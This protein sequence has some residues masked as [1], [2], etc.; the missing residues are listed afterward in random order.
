MNKGNGAPPRTIV[1]ELREREGVNERSTHQNGNYEVKLNKPVMLENGD[2]L[3][4]KSA[5]VDSVQTSAGNL[6]LQE[7]VPVEI[8]SGL[9]THNY[10]TTDK[11][12]NRGIGAQPPA[13]QPDGQ[14]YVLC[15][16]SNAPPTNTLV[17]DSL[18]FHAIGSLFG[19]WGDV[20]VSFKYAPLGGT[21]GNYT[22][23]A[24][25]HIPS[26]RTS[27]ARTYTHIFENPIAFLSNSGVNGTAD[28]VRT[29]PDDTMTSSFV[30]TDVTQT[31]SPF[32]CNG[33]LTPHLQVQKFTIPKGSYS[34][35]ELARF[36]SDQMSTCTASGAL[37]SFPINSPYLTT[38]NQF[39]ASF[40]GD[41][42]YDLAAADGTGILEFTT[43]D[44]Y[45][46]TPQIG[47]EYDQSFN[48]FKFVT[49]NQSIYNNQNVSLQFVRRGQAGNNYF[50]AN[51]SG[52]CFFNKLEPESFWF[53]T[54]GLNANI[55][56]NIGTAKA[57]VGT[58]VEFAVPVVKL[59]DG[60]NTTGSYTG[61]DIAVNKS[62]PLQVPGDISSIVSTSLTQIP[63]YAK[64]A[65]SSVKEGYFKIEV[66]G[67]EQS[68]VGSNSYSNRVQAI[69]GRYYQSSSFTQAYNEGSITYI[70]SGEPQVL[71]SFKVRILNGEN[72]IA[73]GLG[74]D[75][76]VFLE[77]V[78]AVSAD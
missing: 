63:I 76:T 4:L 69:I 7:D 72:Q 78:K 68:L 46:G 1:L 41:P 66:S 15:R 56:T 62:N 43:H 77:L 74:D 36:I 45:I 67:V 57:T 34:P 49:I 28:W 52:G 14:S 30:H 58:D 51:K 39:K 44:Y 54:L 32:G 71:S 29:T 75:S 18:K 64:T 17:M 59:I 26:L 25:V 73:T 40:P 13:T 9:Y 16:N 38:F 19:D 6:I 20:D 5:F 35:D 50:I 48:K 27:H 8:T 23:S 70:H 10:Y 47:F 37:S 31:R 60:V 33:T 2:Q 12:Y 65:F 42:H 61:L 21:L 53:G 24:T 55:Q 3:T 22:A 11:V